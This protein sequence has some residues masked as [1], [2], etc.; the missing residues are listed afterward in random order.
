VLDNLLIVGGLIAIFW[1]ACFVFYLYTSRQQKQIAAD[2]ERLK[3][4]LE[5]SEQ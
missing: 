5:E 3:S 2:I 1:I 4:Q